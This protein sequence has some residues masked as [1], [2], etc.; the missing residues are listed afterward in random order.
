VAINPSRSGSGGGGGGTA[1][2]FGSVAIVAKTLK[3]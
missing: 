3:W 1:I 2:I